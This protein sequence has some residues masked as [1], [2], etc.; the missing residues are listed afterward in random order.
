[1]NLEE[2]LEA[3]MLGEIFMDSQ[4]YPE[5]MEQASLA[6]DEGGLGVVKWDKDTQSFQIVAYFAESIGGPQSVDDIV[7]NRAIIKNDRLIGEGTIERDN[8]RPDEVWF[9]LK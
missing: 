2:M 7:G 4:N 3:A 5:N 6:I 1:M 9:K 8:L